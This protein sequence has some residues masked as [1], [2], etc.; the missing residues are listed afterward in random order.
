MERL[1]DRFSSREAE[2]ITEYEAIC[3]LATL[4]SL[5]THSRIKWAAT[6]FS[7]EATGEALWTR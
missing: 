1:V 4:D 6:F 7:R 3:I 5:N 2:A